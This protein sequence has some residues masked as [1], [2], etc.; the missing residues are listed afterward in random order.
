[1][2]GANLGPELEDVDG[3]LT[4]PTADTP[5]DLD[6]A[7]T[8]LSNLT[9]A[10]EELKAGLEK[11][12]TASDTDV[13]DAAAE[14]DAAAQALTAKN[15]TAAQLKTISDQVTELV[16]KAGDMEADT[17]AK[18][19]ATLVAALQALAPIE[20]PDVDPAPADTEKN[21]T[22]G[23]ALSTIAESA[24]ELASK[25]DTNG[26]VSTENM[27][28]IDDVM[29][30][31]AKVAT[32]LAVDKLE[33]GIVMPMSFDEPQ[34]DGIAKGMASVL[35][36]VAK[37]AATLAPLAGGELGDASKQELGRAMGLMHLAKAK[38]SISKGESS[39]VSTLRSVAERALFLAR[40]ADKL[41]DEVI[42]KES[43]QLRDLMQGLIE[44]Y[45]VKDD[46]FDFSD[47]SIVIDV[48]KK[49]NGIEAVVVKAEEGDAPKPDEAKP[50]EPAAEPAKPAEPAADPA[51]PAEGEEGEVAKAMKEIEGL[52][53]RVAALKAVIAK[54]RDTVTSPASGTEPDE[55]GGAGDDGPL[56]P[57]DFNA[58]VEDDDE[59]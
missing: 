48:D 20:T 41:K 3:G 38:L 12:G 43:A 21:D 51:K 42:K 13:S 27:T 31:I 55:G 58:G 53:G 17:L 59:E 11:N 15:E 33:E 50:D 7:T 19:V 56:F 10:V 52:T 23:A 22:L 46:G 1:M 6:K 49:L 5:T 32:E 45:A 35:R 37:S 29:N 47:Y 28:S 8:A 36:D 4:N 18:E 30:G 25:L 54:A 34:L 26:V 39:F 24:L 40:K 57:M 2:P 16:G 14:A 44:K 9:T